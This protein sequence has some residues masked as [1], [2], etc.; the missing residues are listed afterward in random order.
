[1]RCAMP[2]S[3]RRFVPAA[4]AFA[5][6]L[7]LILPAAAVAGVN[8]W[9]Q[10]GPEGGPLCGI[11]VAPS[12]PLIVY[13]VGYGAGQTTG[14]FRSDDGGQTWV[15]RSAPADSFGCDI[16]VDSADPLRI[17]SIRYTETFQRSFDGGATWEQGGAGLPVLAARSPV[18]VDPNDPNFL[19]IVSLGQ[20]YRSRDRGE[21][22]Q[23]IWLT[24]GEP[25][26][27]NVLEVAVDPLRAGRVFAV[28]YNQGLFLSTTYGDDW[29]PVGQ[30]LPPFLDAKKLV[31]DPADHSV[32]YLL[33]LD[34]IYRTQNG[35]ALWSQVLSNIYGLAD[36]ISFLAVRSDSALFAFKNTLDAAVKQILGSGDRGDTWQ[37]LSSTPSMFPVLGISGLVA[38]PDALLATSRGG[39][40]RSADDGATWQEST[41]GLLGAELAGVEL[42][43][44]N[45]ESMFALDGNYYLHSFRVFRSLDGGGAWQTL[46]PPEPLASAMPVDLAVDP[47][48]SRRLFATTFY[49]DA[50]L[51][52]E[53]AG[54]TWTPHP[55][56]FSCL[57]LQNLVPDPLAQ[58]RL[59]LVGAPDQ[60]SCGAS[61]VTFRS[62]DLGASWQCIGA[63]LADRIRQ[64]AP[65]PHRGGEVLALG[66]RGIYRSSNSG[67][68]WTLVEENPIGPGLTSPFMD[69]EWATAEIAYAAKFGAGLYVSRDS[70]ATWGPVSEGFPPLPLLSDV[71]VDRIHPLNIYVLS[72]GSEVGRSI[73]GGVSWDLLSSGLRGWKLSALRI[74]PVTPNRLYVSAAGGGILAYDVQ[75]PEPCVPSATALCITDGRFKI[76]SLWRDFA[77]NSGVGQAVPLAADTG[78]FWFF[79]P[80]N[81]EL[82]A[83]EIDGVDFNNAYWTFYGALSNVEF[84][85]LATDTATGA[86]HGYFNPSGRF[87]SQG[88][89]L[90]FPQEESVVSPMSFAA[91]LMAPLRSRPAP[92]RSAN[93]CV[94]NA[95]TLC[96]SD[97]RFAASVTWRDFAGRT[98]VGT[99][100]V[101]TPDTGSF[102]F[103]DDGIHELAV[104]VIDGRGTNNAYWVFYGSLSNVEF[105]L[106]VVDTA[107]GE[108]WTRENPSGT[109]ASNGDIEAFPQLP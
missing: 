16:A 59:Y 53:D 93:A 25:T 23:Q 45:P 11:A 107:S 92:A 96:L 52:S 29:S 104:K 67:D 84:T 3:I 56:P 54:E 72:A 42:D 77:G 8:T 70:G 97:G 79:D 10:I 40:F 99:P 75:V 37:V 33:A 21:T 9:T 43:R 22:W 94:P 87:A 27:A 86:Q 76:E 14:F 34:G 78:A 20:L 102:W 26:I 18:A 89:I 46:V 41:A 4:K 15:T 5:A 57:Y 106:T 98:G 108:S 103:F 12:D 95:T 85:L 58:E 88:D 48:Q 39:I 100:L 63:P 35:G 109:F 28:T 24:G 66:F 44:Q 74:D 91:A 81:L 101:L 7:T 50:V 6:A 65:N 1:M 90:S 32:I 47:N 31:F 49:G 55:A 51:R 38:N 83:K 62:D 105:T 64:L 73:D 2:S 68:D 30:G 36:G 19:L 17:Y 60:Y 69:V 13:A 82:F 61:C 80:D 71:V